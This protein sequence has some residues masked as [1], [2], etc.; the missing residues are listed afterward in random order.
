MTDVL[1]DRATSKYPV[2]T[3]EAIAEAKALIG[4]PLRRRPH[5]TVATRDLLLRYAKAIGSRNPLYSDLAHGTFYTYWAGL[6][7]HPTIIFVFDSTF[8]APK[9]PGIH[10][11][12][13]G[14]T[15]E[16]RRQIRAGDRITAT[17]EL[18]AVEKLEGE[19]CGEMVRQT[20]RVEYRNQ[21]GDV[22]AIAKP[23]ALRTPR[24]AARERGKYAHLARYRYSEDEIS[25]IMEAYTREEVR[26][27]KPL[28]FEDV[29]PGSQLPEIVKGPLTTE[30]MNFFVGEVF[31]T[32]FYREFLAHMRRHP[33]DVYWHED[34]NIP[35]SWDASFVI[36]NV[37]QEFG[38]PCAHDTGSPGWSAS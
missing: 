9:L 35:D 11:I 12:Y 32:R 30:D 8:V 33:A 13:G 28:Y 21:G 26:G 25:R 14:V 15:I 7:G 10:T 5:Y 1:T 31:E 37:A 2:L 24:D 20:G 19:F 17:A 36:D 27:D 4:V 23:R 16:W 34:K 6:L 29:V 18:A 38:F 3:P 22:V